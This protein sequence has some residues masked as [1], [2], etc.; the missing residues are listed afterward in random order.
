[1]CN[2]KVSTEK[3]SGYTF[4]TV[5]ITRIVKLRKVLNFMKMHNKF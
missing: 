1:M 5:D 3:E 2:I 4:K